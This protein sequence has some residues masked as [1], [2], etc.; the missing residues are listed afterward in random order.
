MKKPFFFN[1]VRSFNWFKFKVLSPLF[2]EVLLTWYFFQDFVLNRIKITFVITMKSAF[3]HF[4]LFI[5]LIFTGSD[6]GLIFSAQLKS[7]FKKVA[8]WGLR[9]TV[10]FNSLIPCFSFFCDLFIQNPFC[11]VIIEFIFAV[12]NFFFIFIICI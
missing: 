8:I 5:F 3:L 12:S 4:S 2:S 9:D 11:F 7:F 10:D 6:K 1:K